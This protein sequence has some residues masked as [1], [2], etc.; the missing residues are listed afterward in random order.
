[1]SEFPQYYILLDHTPIAVDMMT[2]AKW[3][4]TSF[5]KRRVAHTVINDRCYVSTIFL[6]LN[7]NYFGTGDPV[8]FETMVFGGPLAE[9]GDRYTTWA[10]AE[11]GHEEMVNETRVACKQ[12]DDLAEATGAGQE[13]P[14][15]K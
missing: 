8:L 15:G 6:S 5:D 14:S 1:M 11:R 10:E 3:F 12:V 9:H 7:H 2:W 4:E 13:K